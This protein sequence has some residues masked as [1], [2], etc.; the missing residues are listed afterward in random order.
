MAMLQFISAPRKTH[1][2]NVAFCLLLEATLVIQWW[3]CPFISAQSLLSWCLR[4]HNGPRI[5]LE[6]AWAALKYPDIKDAA[7]LRQLQDPAMV[8]T[9][10]HK[11]SIIR[12]IWAHSEIQSKLMLPLKLGNVCEMVMESRQDQAE[13]QGHWTI[14]C[15]IRTPFRLAG[16]YPIRSSLSPWCKWAG[17]RCCKVMCLCLGWMFT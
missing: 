14:P 15:G 9:N 7:S 13:M 11:V 10:M 12:G 2:V 1:E 5:H 16:K 4:I 17:M 3:L 6:T 8:R